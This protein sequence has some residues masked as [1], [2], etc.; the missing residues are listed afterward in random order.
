MIKLFPLILGT[1]I[2]VTAGGITTITVTTTV[3][4]TAVVTSA[5]IIITINAIVIGVTNVLLLPGHA[6]MIGPPPN[7]V[8]N[9]G[10]KEKGNY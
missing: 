7:G 1:N 10:P 8:S 4:A 3:V 5:V 6:L 2:Y 9:N